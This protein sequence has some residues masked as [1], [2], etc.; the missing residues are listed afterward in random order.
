[1][2]QPN[3][4]KI[5]FQGQNGGYVMI[6]DEGTL[7]VS[8]TDE[9][10][11]DNVIFEKQRVT[12]TENSE[13]IVTFRS[14]LDKSKY[15]CGYEHGHIVTGKP[16][17]ICDTLQPGPSHW[18]LKSYAD[19]TT[20]ADTDSNK[21][22]RVALYHQ[23]TGCYFVIKHDPHSSTDFRL[24]NVDDVPDYGAFVLEKI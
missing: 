7:S 2:A 23:Y 9:P 18:V 8:T 14:Y 3:P 21:S 22:G 11:N 6:N 19:L 12:W 10:G 16:Q 24:S 20:D 4:C 15:L 1:M 13:E 5:N 17:F